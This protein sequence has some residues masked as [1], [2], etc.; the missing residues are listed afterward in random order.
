[1]GQGEEAVFLAKE[2]E[3][4]SFLELLYKYVCLSGNL[5]RIKNEIG[6]RRAI[7]LKA[8]LC[9]YLECEGQDVRTH[10]KKFLDNMPE[11]AKVTNEG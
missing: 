2:A 5:N 9:E 3:V 10:V 1:M 8:F 6:I 7:V 11:F 4:S